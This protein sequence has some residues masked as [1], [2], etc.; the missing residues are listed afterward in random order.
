M[1]LALNMLNAQRFEQVAKSGCEHLIFVLLVMTG[2]DVDEEPITIPFIFPSKPNNKQ[3][4][5]SSTA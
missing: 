4:C 1:S 3:H 2:V 5:S